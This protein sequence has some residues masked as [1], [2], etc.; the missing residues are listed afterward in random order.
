[1]SPARSD[2]QRLELWGEVLQLDELEVVHQREDADTRT[3][4]LTVIPRHSLGVCP[5]CGELSQDVHQRRDRE[6]IRDLAIG[7]RQVELRVRVSQFWCRR[8]E[9]A[10][11]PPLASLAEGTHA[12]ERFL[13]RCATLIRHGDVARAA[14]FLGLPEKTLARWYYEY[15]ERRQQQPAAERQPIRAIGIDELSLKKSTVSSWR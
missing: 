12:T 11:T 14:A 8:C 15:V 9:Q 1:M 3:I 4:H 10:F 13:E 6:G 7:G 5:C 2:E